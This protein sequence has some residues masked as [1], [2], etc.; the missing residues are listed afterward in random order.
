VATCLVLFAAA[1]GGDSSNPPGGVGGGGGVVGCPSGQIA[2]GDS[3]VPF[4]VPPQ[5]CAVGYLWQDG[6]CIPS[7]P[8]EPCAPGTVALPGD[9]QCHALANCEGDVWAKLPAGSVTWVDAAYSGGGS[10]GTS[11]RPF[12]S[13]QAAVDV[14]PAFGVVAVESGSYAEDVVIFERPVQLWGRCPTAVTLLGGGTQIAPLIVVN[15]GTDSVIHDVGV[16]GNGLGIAVSAAAVTLSRVWVHDLPNIGV[17]VEDQLGP[18]AVHVID[19]LVENVARHGM[20]AFG[21]ALTVERTV[22]RDVAPVAEAVPNG[23]AL[24]AENNPATG[25]RALVQ[26]LGSVLMRAH[27][28]GLAVTG[29][30]VSVIGTTIRDVFATPVDPPRFGYGIALQQGLDG[31]RSVAMV[32]AS[33]LGQAHEFGLYVSSS[34]ATV[35]ATTILEIRPRTS[36]EFGD[37]AVAI[38]L[39]DTT[40]LSIGQSLFQ[41]HERAAIS[42]FGGFVELADSTLICNPIDLDVEPDAATAIEGTIADLG[43]NRCGCDGELGACKVVSTMLQPPD[44]PL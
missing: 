8:S 7:L 26:V 41:G 42:A 17:D 18:A 11:E 10:D 37:G 12:T 6:G 27:D 44:A 35:N 4:G 39:P 30:D 23:R 13:I 15:E 32:D 21:A 14:A 43:G 9:A 34:E 5:A 33:F 29:S 22:V 19:S 2:E 31:A 40:R 28:A 1:C 24:T 25:A 36:G 38:G 16:A 20:F 3:C